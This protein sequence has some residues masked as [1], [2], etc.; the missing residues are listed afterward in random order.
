VATISN[1]GAYTLATLV[2]GVYDIRVTKEDLTTA[3]ST[4]LMWYTPG[5]PACCT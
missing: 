3:V 2:P 4:A 5:L 1:T